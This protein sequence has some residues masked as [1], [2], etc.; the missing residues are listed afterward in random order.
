VRVRA[1]RTR[2]FAGARLQNV[3]KPPAYLLPTVCLFYTSSSMAEPG[4]GQRNQTELF[5]FS[6]AGL[7]SAEHTSIQA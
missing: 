7:V 5:Y 6:K 2:I 3:I 4:V 1:H